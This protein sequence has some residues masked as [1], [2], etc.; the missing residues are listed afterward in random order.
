MPAGPD[1]DSTA[2]EFITDVLDYDG[3]RP[4]TVY[5]PVG[6]VEAVV[7]CGDGALVAEWGSDLDGW[8]GPPT[9]LVGVHGHQDETTRL[10]EYSPGF[11]EPRFVAHEKFVVEDVRRWVQ[12]RFGV[13]PIADRTAAYGASAGGE[14]ALA[15]GLRHPDLFG[16]VLCA[17]PGAG[18]RPPVVL[19]RSLPRT[20]LVAGNDEPFFLANATRWARA[21]ED[22]GAD[23]VFARRDGA[24]GDPFWRAEFRPMISWAFPPRP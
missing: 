10:G 17:S 14:F 13:T 9:M 16:A 24:H 21:L 7:F 12:S 3:G 20:Y 19:P 1:A 4:V 23:V 6:R 18:Y 8:D 5:R 11:D 15:L 22:A 2:G